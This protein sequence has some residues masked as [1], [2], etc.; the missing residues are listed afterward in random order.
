MSRFILSL[1]STLFL[2]GMIGSASVYASAFPSHRD[3]NGKRVF[4][5]SPKSH[6]WAA[7]NENG[8]RVNEGRASGGKNYCP[9]IHRGCKTIV[10]TFKVIAKKGVY[11]K[12][13]KFPRPRGGAP[14][15]YCMYFHPK[16]Y[17]IHGSSD[18]PN[19]NASHGC[20]RVTPETAKWLNQN[21]ITVGTVVIV[22]P[23]H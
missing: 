10:G 7:Y 11:C 17:A 21:F 1:C 20:I 19:A 23:Y 14:M 12:S 16:G 2:I 8:R 4:I 6:A 9:D 13:S 15:P 3:T 18:V 5:F 22:L